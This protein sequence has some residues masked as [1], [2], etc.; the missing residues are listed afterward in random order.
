ML[1]DVILSGDPRDALFDA[2]DGDRVAQFESVVAGFLGTFLGAAVVT[3]LQK[4]SVGDAA[5]V[6]WGVTLARLFAIA[7]KVSVGVAVLAVGGSAIIFG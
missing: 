7:L 6:G 2:D 3:L 1:S 4:R 5:R